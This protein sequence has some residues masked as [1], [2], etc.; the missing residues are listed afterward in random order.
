MTPPE[1]RVVIPDGGIETLPWAAPEARAGQGFTDKSDVYSLG[2]LLF[3]LL[4][5]KVPTSKGQDAPVSPRVYARACPEDLAF[6]IL[7]A[8]NPDPQERPSA[9]QLAARLE[10]VLVEDGTCLRD[11]PRCRYRGPFAPPAPPVASE[12]LAGTTRGWTRFMAATAEPANVGP[13]PSSVPR[14]TRPR[15][16][17][18]STRATSSSGRRPSSRTL[19]AV[20]RRAGRPCRRRAGCPGRS[21]TLASPRRRAAVLLVSAAGASWSGR[22]V[23]RA[24]Q[25]PMAEPTASTW[26]GQAPEVSHMPDPTATAQAVPTATPGTKAGVPLPA[27]RDALNRVS[28]SLL[29]CARL[30]G[31]VLLVEFKTA[32]HRERFAG[33][34][35]VGEESPAVLRCVDEALAPVRFAP[36]PVQTLTEEYTL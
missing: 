16:S 1:S 11:R 3:R 14:T 24:P 28:G 31:G 2:L 12:P 6:A 23:A 26:A 36:A 10:D 30:A 15:R 34:R 4:T 8:L 33:T 5:G 18:H 29:D 9:A 21:P 19:P 25:P 22:R 20:G 7:S 35:V 27:M 32:E 17:F 13:G